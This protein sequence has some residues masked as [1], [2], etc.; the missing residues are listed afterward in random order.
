MLTEAQLDGHLVTYAAAPPSGRG[1]LLLHVNGVT[2]PYANQERDL[3]ALVWLTLNHPCDVIGIHNGTEGFRADLM[4]SLLGKAELLR[5]WPEYRNPESE[6]RLHGYADLIRQ[7]AVLDL[8]A[9]ADI[10]KVAAGLNTEL[11]VAETSKPGLNSLFDLDLVKRLPLVQKMGWAEFESYFYGSYPAGAPRPTL[12]LAYEILKGIRTG[13]EI[14]VVTHSQG[15][16]IAA[17]AFQIL[18]QFFGGTRAWSQ[19]IRFIGY[20]PVILFADLPDCIQTQ[21]VLI[22]YRLDSVADS[23]SNLRNLGF[24]GNLQSQF[25]NVL[26]NYD[27]LASSI[28]S[29]S[30]HSA[31]AYLGLLPA[32][33]ND[34]SAKL[35]Q[36]LL[37]Q[38]WQ[39]NPLIAALCKTRIILEE[40]I[41]TILPT[42]L[43]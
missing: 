38:N 14:F 37:T 3:E 26:E 5:F 42:D 39:T 32:P 11:G 10:L 16:I 25:K 27:N 4:E 7:L 22:Q 36:L 33:A 2:S 43:V 24:W 23:L 1:R 19:N 34:R 35:I 9:D 18:Q 6:R 21:T 31:S 17:L 13:A 30:H 12:R 15:C 40:D 29:D 41:P 20:G 28:N 8:A